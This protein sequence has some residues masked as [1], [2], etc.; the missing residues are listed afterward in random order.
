MAEH[1]RVAR[2][3]EAAPLREAAD[4]AAAKST[5]GERVRHGTHWSPRKLL[6]EAESAIAWTCF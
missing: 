4:G 1:L 3:F 5:G 6:P 2:G